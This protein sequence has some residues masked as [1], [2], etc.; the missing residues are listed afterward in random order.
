MVTDIFKKYENFNIYDDI[1][2][3][4]KL[5]KEKYNVKLLFKLINN[6]E[7]NEKNKIK[8]L[9]LN[10]IKDIFNYEIKDSDVN[11]KSDLNSVINNFELEEGNNEEINNIEEDKNISKENDLKDNQNNQ[12]LNDSISYCDKEEVNQEKELFDIES[13][14]NYEIK[15]KND[16]S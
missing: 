9:G 7:E 6:C 3:F 8:K 13:D 12:K 10:I 5:I 2:H 4:I 14:F 15:K 16:D 11:D 1:Y